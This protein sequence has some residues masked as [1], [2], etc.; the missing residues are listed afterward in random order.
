[1]QPIVDRTDA[2]S[3]AVTNPCRQLDP[4]Q[5]FSAP[6]ELKRILVVDDEPAIIYMLQEGLAE[7]T[8]CEIMVAAD[9]HQALQLLETGCVDLVITDYM[10]PG[11]DGLTLIGHIQRLCP[12]TVMILLTAYSSDRL[13]RQ[14]AD[15]AIQYV[16]NKPIKLSELR[17]LVL[18]L[19]DQ[20]GQRQETTT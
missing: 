4:V 15:L 17:S 3:G 9:G 2:V 7:T 5:P 16:L 8:N 18:T 13:C 14:A 12:Q 10:M 20:S 19:L 6:I 11:M 1:M